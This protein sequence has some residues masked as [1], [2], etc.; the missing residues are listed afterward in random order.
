[1][2][3]QS[4]CG[5]R[6]N[7]LRPG[8]LPASFPRSRPRLPGRL[9]RSE[10][11]RG[12]SRQIALR[13][14]GRAHPAAAGSRLL[15]SFPAPQATG[16]QELSPARPPDS[17]QHNQAPANR[18]CPA[19][20]GCG[21]RDRL[22]GHVPPRSNRDGLPA[23]ATAAGLPGKRGAALAGRPTG[24]VRAV[25]ADRGRGISCRRIQSQRRRAKAFPCPAAPSNASRPCRPAV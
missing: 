10:R 6:S 17:A 15:Q 25:P 22:P 5:P 23:A 9:V 13:R 7:R 11:L 20:G 21:R 3:A 4:A 18:R 16:S 14:V 1:M 19:G 2:F 12:M 8:A 24:R